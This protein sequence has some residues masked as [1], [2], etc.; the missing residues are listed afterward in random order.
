MKSARFE[1]QRYVYTHA[2]RLRDQKREM[3][4]FGDL[5]WRLFDESGERRETPVTTPTCEWEVIRLLADNFIEAWEEAGEANDNLRKQKEEMKRYGDMHWRLYHNTGHL[6]DEPINE[7]SR[8]W[9]VMRRLLGEQQL[10]LRDT[11]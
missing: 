5:H 2:A 1:L 6:R 7:A 10:A 3:D 8:N 9:E 11:V 4:D